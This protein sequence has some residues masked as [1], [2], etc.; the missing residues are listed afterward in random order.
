MK[1]KKTITIILM[2]S[3][4]SLT[5]YAQDLD[6]VEIQRTTQD[7]SGMVFID[8]E[9]VFVNID[10]VEQTI[11]FEF[12]TGENLFISP[13]GVVSD[14]DIRDVVC[15]ILFTLCQKLRFFLDK[16]ICL[17]AVYMDCIMG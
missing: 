4:F 7:W 15:E 14:G 11:F 2:L 3:F 5:S 6:I 1:I 9:E 8:E 13:A 17:L 12:E 16:I 10:K